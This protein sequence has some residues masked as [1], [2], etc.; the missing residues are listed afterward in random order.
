MSKVGKNKKLKTKKTE[1]KLYNI[2]VLKGV[3][4]KNE[5][6][7]THVKTEYLNKNEM[8][9]TII[10]TYVLKKDVYE[11]I[12]TGDVY[13]CNMTNEDLMKTKKLPMLYIDVTWSRT[14]KKMKLY[15]IYLFFTITQEVRSKNELLKKSLKGK[16]SLE[17]CYENKYEKIEREI[18]NYTNNK[19]MLNIMKEEAMKEK[20]MLYS[21]QEV[22]KEN[23]KIKEQY[24]EEMA[25]YT[26]PPRTTIKLEDINID[27]Y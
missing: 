27:D 3:E 26:N 7:I 22:E 23:E 10:E 17:I 25:R 1:K 19:E 9:D 5:M 6:K 11:G 4:N 14:L 15:R 12:I 18:K 24:G 13:L 16:Y 2:Y 20:L 8:D 21:D